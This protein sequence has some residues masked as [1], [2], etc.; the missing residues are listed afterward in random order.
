VPV[1]PTTIQHGSY[2]KVKK[3]FFWVVCLIKENMKVMFV[4]VVNLS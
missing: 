2:L 3:H 1:I 4:I